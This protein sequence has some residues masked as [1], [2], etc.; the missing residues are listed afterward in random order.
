MPEILRWLIVVMTLIAI[1]AGARVRGHMDE[2]PLAL[3]M[4]GLGVGV[5]FAGAAY[6]ETLPHLAVH[7]LPFAALGGTVVLRRG[8]RLIVNQAAS[9]ITT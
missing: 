8:M 4:F 9:D 7:W 3:V 1:Y 2:S 5:G 6:A